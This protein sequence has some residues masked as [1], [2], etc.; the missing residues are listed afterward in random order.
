MTIGEL[1]EILNMFPDDVEIDPTEQVIQLVGDEFKMEVEKSPC[2][3][4]NMTQWSKAACCGC[5]EYFDW[6]KK[7]RKKQNG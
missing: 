3:S 6:L 4:C 7:E 5:E 2:A 1:K